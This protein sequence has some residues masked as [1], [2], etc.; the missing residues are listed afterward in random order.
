MGTYL[1]VRLLLYT[2]ANLDC[3][4]ELSHHNFTLEPMFDLTRP[5]AFVIHGYRPTGAPPIWINHIVH[6]LAAQEDMNILVVDWNRGAA[7]L[8]YFT[9]VAN[10]RRTAANITAFIENMEVSPHTPHTGRGTRVS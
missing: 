8:N 1:Y 10:T 5:T 4:Q 7:N 9:A 6:L 3:G 2:R